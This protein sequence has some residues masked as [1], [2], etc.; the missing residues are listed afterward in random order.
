M[1]HRKESIVAKYWCWNSQLSINSIDI[2]WVEY[3]PYRLMR[4]VETDAEDGHTSKHKQ[5]QDHYKLIQYRWHWL[6]YWYH[7]TISK[8][9]L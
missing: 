8:V 6:A 3:I 2:R 1:L 5:F 7:S 9:R 4:L